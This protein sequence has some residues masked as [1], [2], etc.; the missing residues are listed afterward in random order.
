MGNPAVVVALTLLIVFCHLS[1]GSLLVTPINL[2]FAISLLDY[3]S[4]CL[5]SATRHQNLV[6]GA[7]T[8]PS[9]HHA[10][11]TQHTPRTHHVHTTHTPHTHHAHTTHTSRTHTTH[12][13][14][15]HHAHITHTSRGIHHAHINDYM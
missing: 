2:S 6:F 15:T 13:S 3:G 8:T 14:R 9:T 11:I 4:S 12:T 5:P 1:G 10:Q 7:C